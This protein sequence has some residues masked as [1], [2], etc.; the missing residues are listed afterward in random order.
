MTESEMT[1]GAVGELAHDTVMA[2]LFDGDIRGKHGWDK[3]TAEYHILRAIAH[4][5]RHLQGDTTET[6]LDNALTR[7]T[8]AKWVGE[9]RGNVR[10]DEFTSGE[11]DQ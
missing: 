3:H 10:D 11:L 7:L 1:Y 6:N 2:V 4:C 5:V 8:M 9:W